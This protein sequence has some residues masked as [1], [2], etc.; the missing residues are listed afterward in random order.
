MSVVDNFVKLVFV[1]QYFV[2]L[3]MTVRITFFVSAVLPHSDGG[4]TKEF[5]TI[6]FTAV[7]V[8]FVIFFKE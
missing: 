8:F 3:I 2:L 6:V 7:H 4:H 5:S 1:L